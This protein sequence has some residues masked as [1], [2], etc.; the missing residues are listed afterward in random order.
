MKRLLRAIEVPR[1]LLLGRYPD[2]VTGGTLR[3]GQVPVFVFH[4][5][6][7]EPFA[8][9][10]RHL[11]D[12]G[13]VTLSVEEYFQVLTNARTAPERAVL[14]T[15]D[16]GRASVYSVAYPLLKR[17]GMKAV[18]FLVPS[19]IGNEPARPLGDDWRALTAPP[20]N[21]GFLSWEEVRLLAA[22]G[23][24]EFQSHSLSHARIHTGPS[25]AG[26]MTPELQTG[27]AALDAPRIHQAG[28]DL[29]PQEVALGTPL[30]RS[31]PRLSEALR[32]Y[33]DPKVREACVQR[34]ASQGG[35]GFFLRED[36]RQQLRRLLDGRPI[37]G[38]Y[39]TPEE[40]EAAIR[41]ELSD[42][43]RLI[44]EQT[45]RPVL[46]VCYPWHVA[47]PTTLRVARETGH[48]AAFCGKVAGVP[49]SLPG[50]DPFR[51]ARIG[52]D[53]LLSLPGKDRVPLTEILREKWSRRLGRPRRPGR[54]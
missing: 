7:P 25:V 43:R 49:I 36:W 38:R 42:A 34:V 1:D 8:R 47:G 10:L 46:H 52:E 3:R 31:E 13:Y 12:N 44:E 6:E 17:H 14:L 2:F 23:L 4:S 9:K 33:E 35:P 40:R 27:Y 54:P 48:R 30:L 20:A 51:I 37:P 28:R 41:R 21:E 22:S 16:D 18:V 53:W 50:G 32:F 15:L 19:R 24:F 45:G 5:I 39:E 26:F 11:A 29:D